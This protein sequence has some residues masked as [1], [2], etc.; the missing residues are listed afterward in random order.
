M[1]FMNKKGDLSITVIIIA[2]LALLVLVVLSIIFL[3]RTNI[4]VDNVSDCENNG[5]KCIDADSCT[6]DYS[7]IVDHV[8]DADSKV[9]CLTVGGTTDE[10]A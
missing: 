1:K 4:F 8:C 3:G 7:R 5:G 9:C 6:G 2:A 10:T